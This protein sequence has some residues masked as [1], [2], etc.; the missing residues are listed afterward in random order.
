MVLDSLVFK[1]NLEMA[2]YVPNRDGVYMKYSSL[3]SFNDGE[4][5]LLL[6]FSSE[7]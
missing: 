2:A 3:A 1:R 5:Y 7:S 6:F 4:C